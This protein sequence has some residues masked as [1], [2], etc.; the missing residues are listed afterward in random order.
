MFAYCGDNPVNRADISGCSW[1]WFDF[2][3]RDIH[4]KGEIGRKRILLDRLIIEA[5]AYKQDEYLNEEQMQVNATIIYTELSEKGWS[6]NAICAVLG[7]MQQESN[8]NP[9]MTERGGGSGF[10]LVQWTP[11]TK[12]TNWADANGRRYNSILGQLRFLIV[13][14]QPGA[15]EWF[16]NRNYPDYYLSAN[17][18]ICS[19]ASTDYLTAVFLY[20]YERAGSP[21]L[22][23][24]QAYA[25][26]WADY[27]S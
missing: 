19:T 27:F 15:G 6:H 13:S 7:N 5:R 10:G 2:W 23:N 12:Y 14:M 20:S 22:E 9:G 8:I 25:R 24:R 1:V 4:I 3:K 17:E 18:F 21:H 26:Y 16:Q 11:S